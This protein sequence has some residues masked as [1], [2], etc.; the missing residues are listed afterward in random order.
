MEAFVLQLICYSMRS[1][2][3]TT[4]V[5][6]DSEPHPSCSCKTSFRFAQ[7]AVRRNALQQLKYNEHWVDPGN[8]FKGGPGIVS[9]FFIAINVFYRGMYEPPLRSNL[10]Q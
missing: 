10:T 5:V 4:G 7:L 2:S 1:D 9:S 8:S 6:L 3:F